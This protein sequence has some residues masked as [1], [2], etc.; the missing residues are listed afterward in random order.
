MVS[1][2]KV[3]LTK[4]QKRVYDVMNKDEIVSITGINGSGKTTAAVAAIKKFIRKATDSVKILYLVT[5]QDMESTM[6]IFK[7]MNLNTSDEK[8]YLKTITDPEKKTVSKTTLESEK[9]SDSS[10]VY[11]LTPKSYYRYVRGCKSKSYIK[12]MES[13]QDPDEKWDMTVID[14]C[15]SISKEFKNL[16][17]Q[18]ID[19][20]EKVIVMYGTPGAI[21]I[22]SVEIDDTPLVFDTLE[23]KEVEKSIKIQ[24]DTENKQTLWIVIIIGII[25]MVCAILSFMSPIAFIFAI[26]FAVVLFGIGY[27]YS[28]VKPVLIACMS[29]GG[30]TAY[31]GVLGFIIITC[32]NRKKSQVVSSTPGICSGVTAPSCQ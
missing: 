23:N 27:M 25:G 6:E 19:V 16:V 15:A 13:K 8:E 26:I 30:M 2:K 32:S 9:E 12:A 17:T 22:E 10:V 18:I 7:S 1:D 21:D 28:D 3:K 20:S 31:I 5:P 4:S 24:E 29:T 14:R 11:L